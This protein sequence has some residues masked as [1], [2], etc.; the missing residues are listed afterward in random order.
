[1]SHIPMLILGLFCSILG[2]LNI[3]GN[4]SSIH[5]Y[6]R[7]KVTEEDIPKY[8]RA[9]GCGT[10]IMGISFIATA[11]LQMIFKSESLYYIVAFGIVIGLAFIL[12]GQFKY[13]RGIF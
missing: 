8:G 13:N 4:V 5:W 6:N 12:Y 10:L 7:R 9:V 1:M 11:I 2:V 3:K